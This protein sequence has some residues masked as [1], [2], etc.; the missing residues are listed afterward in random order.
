MAATGFSKRFWFIGTI[1]PQEHWKAHH[2]LIFIQNI[3][4]PTES[5]KRQL[6]KYCI[7]FPFLLSRIRCRIW[8]HHPTSFVGLLHCWHCSYRISCCFGTDFIMAF[9]FLLGGLWFQRCPV[10]MS[11][12]FLC[13]TPRRS[14][15]SIV[16]LL[17]GIAFAY[18]SQSVDRR[19][20][21]SPS[22]AILIATK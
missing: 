8:L 1:N 19:A 9:V 11:L 4:I 16:F 10:V 2:L 15:F 13:E 22:K 6:C 21:S 7:Y 12:L 17:F 20:S 18:W 5:S 3:H 14:F